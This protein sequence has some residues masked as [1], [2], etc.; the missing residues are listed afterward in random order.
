ME[1]GLSE[2]AT[3]KV[4]D[5]FKNSRVDEDDYGDH[6]SLNDAESGRL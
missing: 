3:T 1:T 5:E 2:S 6:Q 4:R